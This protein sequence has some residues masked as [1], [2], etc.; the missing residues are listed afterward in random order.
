[1][2]S[3]DQ[4]LALQG[5]NQRDVL[6][7]QSSLAYL[8]SNLILAEQLL[9]RA[10]PPPPADPLE[11]TQQLY[12]SAS[13]AM[14]RGRYDEAIAYCQRSLRYDGQ[15]PY[16][17]YVL[18]LSY[19]RRAQKLQS[20]EQFAAARSH[21]QKVLDINPDLAEAEFARKNILSIDAALR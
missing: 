9:L 4:A 18:A 3:L 5:E 12:Q 21:F 6:R 11:A 8:Q 17:H 2:P 10:Q 19:A 15:E 13:L 1:M 7:A 16:V 20:V 14:E